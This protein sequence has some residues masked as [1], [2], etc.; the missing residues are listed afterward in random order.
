MDAQL[1]NTWLTTAE[2][3]SNTGRLL[4]I[5]DEVA[6]YIEK[7]YEIKFESINGDEKR[8]EIKSKR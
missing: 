2:L 3:Y 6:D 4:S 1:K 7:F 5:S 8:Y